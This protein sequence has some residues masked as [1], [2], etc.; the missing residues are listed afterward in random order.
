MKLK[1]AIAGTGKV[2]TQNYLPF[3]SRQDGIELACWNRTP[4]KAGEAARQSGAIQSASLEDLVRWE[5][6]SVFVLTSETVRDTVAT[7]L[8]VAGARRLYLE[9]PLVAL[10]G[11]A[12]VTPDDFHRGKALRDLAQC[13]GC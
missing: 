9:K 5:P 10:A 8:I 13:R 11:Q 7:D 1:I 4:D 6:D 12:H 2:A 3:L